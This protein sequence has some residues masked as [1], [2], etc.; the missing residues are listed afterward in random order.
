MKIQPKNNAIFVQRR[1]AEEVSKGGIVLTGT[2]KVAINDGVI[3]HVALCSTENYAG[4]FK[5]GQRVLFGEYA[6][7]PVNIEGVSYIAMKCEDIIAVLEEEEEVKP[8]GFKVISQP[9]HANDFSATL[10]CRS[11]DRLVV[12]SQEDDIQHKKLECPECGNDGKIVESGD[13]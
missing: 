1:E 2:S 4:E 9:S 12:Y 5:V 8:T 11:C 10:K 7:Q 3:T 13:E 6:G